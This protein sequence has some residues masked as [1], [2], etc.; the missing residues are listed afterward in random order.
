M[1]RLLLLLSL[2][3]MGTSGCAGHDRLA[4]RCEWPSE[5]AASLDLRDQAKQRHLRDDAR[6]AEGLAIRYTDSIRAPQQPGEHR[7]ATEQ[8]EATLFAAIARVHGVV[9]QQVR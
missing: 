9:P 3:F 4:A 1:T 7:R 5:P 6:A 8:C 2:L